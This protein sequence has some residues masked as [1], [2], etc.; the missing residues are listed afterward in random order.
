[1]LTVLPVSGLPE[2]SA[3]DDLA[4]LVAARA[5]LRDRDVVVVAQ[6]VVSK[7]EGALLWAR[8]GEDRAA[9]RR[10][11]ARAEAAR[12]VVDAPGALVVETR[13][14]LV[15]ANAGIDAS[16]VPG[17]AFLRLPADPDRSAR[18]L[19]AGL[20]AVAGVEVAVIVADTFGRPWRT[21]V[22]DVAIGVAGLHPLRDERGG[23][24]RHGNRLEATCVAVADELAAAADLVRRKADGVP[25]VVVR[26]YVYEADE[27]AGAGLL[28]RRP[29]DDLF[30]RGR[31][32]LAD[33]LG[34]ASPVAAGVD[35]A[36]LERAAGAARRVGG[37]GVRVASAGGVVAVAG[38]DLDAGAGAGAAIAALVD[39]GYLAAR[40]PPRPGEEATVVVVGGR[41]AEPSDDRGR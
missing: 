24:D 5:D 22:T 41:P 14:G 27:R 3:G 12:V 7:A 35:P 9:A 2:V 11:L 32:A 6:K 34:T 30:R 23:V 21:G 17:G 31:G 18:A 4:A 37:A 40:R 1:M 38:P 26:G 10:R 36:D 19:R 25:V 8:P 13:H 28:R 29:E 16:N 33:T 39:L 15:C 20:R